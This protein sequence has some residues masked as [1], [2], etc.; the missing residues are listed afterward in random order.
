M[1]LPTALNIATTAAVV[2]GVIFGGWQI[3]VAARMRQT[4]IS[5]HLIEVL[6]ARDLMEALSVLNDLPGGLS[7]TEMQAALGERW[8]LVFTLIQTLAGMGILVKRGEVALA[9]SDDFFHH[10]VAIVWQKSRT[11]ILE[12]RTNNRGRETAFIFL[13][14]LAKRQETYRAER[15]AAD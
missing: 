9:V 6:Y 7:W 12:R 1:D 2:G 11:A 15:R 4:Q 3:R 13:E 8:Y 10:A 5:L 14:W